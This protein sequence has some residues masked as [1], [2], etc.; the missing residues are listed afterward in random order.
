[1]QLNISVQGY[2]IYFIS[3]LEIL[4]KLYYIV[5]FFGNDLFIPSNKTFTVSFNL[6]K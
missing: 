3:S 2:T 4:H 6:Q 1:M 5:I